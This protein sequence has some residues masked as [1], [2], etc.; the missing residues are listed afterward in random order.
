MAKFAKKWKRRNKNSPRLWRVKKCNS[1]LSLNFGV[2]SPSQTR[3]IFSIYFLSLSELHGPQNI[4]ICLSSQNK[5]TRKYK[6]KK[7][8]SESGSESTTAKRE[9]N[10]NASHIGQN[11]PTHIVKSLRIS[12]C[13]RNGG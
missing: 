12:S 1:K 9:L 8:K 11:G 10:S 13:G 2:N 7:Y 3:L 5:K 6:L 4:S